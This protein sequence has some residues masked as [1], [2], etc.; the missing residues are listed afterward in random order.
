MDFLEAVNRL[1]YK[2][3][4]PVSFQYMDELARI[5]EDD[6]ARIERKTEERTIPVPDELISFLP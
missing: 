1:E 2:N 3:T 5:I 4:Q 6:Y